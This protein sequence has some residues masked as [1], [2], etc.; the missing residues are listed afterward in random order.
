MPLLKTLQGNSHLMYSLS[1]VQLGD[2]KKIMK[3]TFSLN[4][5]PRLEILDMLKALNLNWVCLKETTMNLQVAAGLQ[6]FDPV[7]L[8]QGS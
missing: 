1:T 7:D 2:E 4:L 3:I 8:Y 5:M 6:T